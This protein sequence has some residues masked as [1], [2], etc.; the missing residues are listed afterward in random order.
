MKTLDKITLQQLYVEDQLTIREIAEKLSIRPR[1]VYDAMIHWRVP[2]RPKSARPNRPAPTLHYDEA[3][4][5]Y[6]YLDLG[7]TI[8]EIA[9]QLNISS[10]SVYTA[11]KRWNIPRRRC[12]PKPLR[13]PTAS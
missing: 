4:I 6:H 5:R 9:I 7:Q 13:P 1:V 2:R 8:K 3:T 12:G 10:G 11:M